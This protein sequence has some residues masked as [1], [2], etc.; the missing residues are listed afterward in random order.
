MNSDCDDPG[1]NVKV[2]L[3][4]TAGFLFIF[5]KYVGDIGI[6]RKDDLWFFE[7]GA[8]AS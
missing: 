3:S 4:C 2:S 7:R 8:E 5:F 1:S 6:E